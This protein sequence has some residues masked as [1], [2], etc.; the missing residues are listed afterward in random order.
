VLP[1]RFIATEVTEDTEFLFC[2]KCFS[3]GSISI[4]KITTIIRKFLVAPSMKPG[5]SRLKFV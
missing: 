5:K 2:Y 1:Q 3:L 4:T